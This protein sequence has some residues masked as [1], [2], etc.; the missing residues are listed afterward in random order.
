MILRLEWC[1]E[2]LRIGPKLS[3]ELITMPDKGEGHSN[4]PT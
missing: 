4:I 3:L 1:K 2:K